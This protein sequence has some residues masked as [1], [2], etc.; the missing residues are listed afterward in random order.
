MNL[1]TGFASDRRSSPLPRDICSAASQ[2]V[3]RAQ[4]DMR[5]R[6][7]SLPRPKPTMAALTDAADR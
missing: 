2:I 4:Q 3:W 7:S 1:H 6:H 5:G